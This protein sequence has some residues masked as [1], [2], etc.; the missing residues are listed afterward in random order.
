MS[1]MGRGGSNASLTHC[2]HVVQE[3]VE[4]ERV[5]HMKDVARLRR[6]RSDARELAARARA[7]QVRGMLPCWCAVC[8]RGV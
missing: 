8:V 3:S 2:L 5:R 7:R 4:V 6:Q 1:R